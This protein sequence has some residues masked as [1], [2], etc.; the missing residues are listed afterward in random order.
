[1]LYYS[2]RPGCFQNKSR[3]TSDKAFKTDLEEDI[4]RSNTRAKDSVARNMCANYV[5]FPFRFHHWKIN[6][7]RH[8]AANYKLFVREKKP[9]YFSGRTCAQ[10]YPVCHLRPCQHQG[11][12]VETT[13]GSL[14]LCMPGFEGQWCHMLEGQEDQRLESPT[15]RNESN[16]LATTPRT[17]KPST[18]G[19][20]IS[21]KIN[22]FGSG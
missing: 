11:T 3:F 10:R 22:L 2:I 12:C 1:M 19:T 9:L 13:S 4:S 21:G 18:P 6:L 7:T 17:V 8:L 15:S 14:C 20:S 5:P 16:S